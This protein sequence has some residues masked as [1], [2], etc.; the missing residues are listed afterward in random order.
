MSQRKAA[1]QP[2][3]RANPAAANVPPN[4]PNQPSPTGADVTNPNDPAGWPSTGPVLGGVAP[5]APPTGVDSEPSPDLPEST[6]TMSRLGDLPT[7]ASLGT[8]A[9]AG[10][11]APPDSSVQLPSGQRPQATTSEMGGVAPFT[12]PGVI[13]N[14][15]AITNVRP[16]ARR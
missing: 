8:L 4:T 1:S 11:V 15:G 7:P 3:A 12:P 14:P 10:Q 6:T 5:G 13:A 2:T 9:P 16:P